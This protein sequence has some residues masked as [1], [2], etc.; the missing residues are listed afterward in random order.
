[1]SI[2]MIP[3]PDILDEQLEQLRSILEL[4]EEE[5]NPELKE[6]RKWIQ[7]EERKFQKQKQRMIIRGEWIS[8]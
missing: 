6:L 3:C 4:R 7:E 8:Y 2:F 1:M 5:N